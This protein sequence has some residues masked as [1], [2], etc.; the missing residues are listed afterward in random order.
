MTLIWRGPPE[1]VAVLRA[2]AAP[3]LPMVA[4][5]PLLDVITLL[6]LCWKLFLVEFLVDP[7]PELIVLFLVKEPIRLLLFT[8]GLSPL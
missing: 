7:N 4:A 1:G 5:L 8:W 6:L 2:I 3:K